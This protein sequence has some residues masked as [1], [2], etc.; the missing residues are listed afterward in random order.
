MSNEAVPASPP[1]VPQ[2]AENTYVFAVFASEQADE[3]AQRV[4]AAFPEDASYQ[5]PNGDWL[6]A[7]KT[8][9]ASMI[10]DR[11]VG[12]GGDLSML[13]ARLMRPYGFHDTAIWDWI[14]AKENAKS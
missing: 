10:Y 5:L 8:S 11:I 12:E 2:T 7:E 1:V 6:V 4:I 3:L 14:E 9:K 13:V